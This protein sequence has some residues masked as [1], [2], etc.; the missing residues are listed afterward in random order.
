VVIRIFQ[1]ICSFRPLIAL[2]FALAIVLAFAV[3][4]C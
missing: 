2:A 3:A 4:C 1:L